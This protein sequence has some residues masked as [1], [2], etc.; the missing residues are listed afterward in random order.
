MDRNFNGD[1]RPALGFAGN[2][3]STPHGMRAL[4]HIQ[5]AEM[6]ARRIIL[7]AETAPVVGDAE[8]NLFFVV[9]EKRIHFVGAA[10]LDG[11]SH[12]FL[13]DTKQVH[14]DSCGQPDW[15]AT[16][17]DFYPDFIPTRRQLHNLTQGGHQ[18]PGDGRL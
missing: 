7:R 1:S 2:F 10:V 16:N 5:Q 4:A 12:G 15:S 13:P 9:F 8:A 14:F 6:P 11:V 18:V 3:K 17:A